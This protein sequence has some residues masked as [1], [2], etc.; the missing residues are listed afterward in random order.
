MD[1]GVD[2]NLERVEAGDPQGTRSAE[3]GKV[4]ERAAEATAVLELNLEKA[5]PAAKAGL[6]RALEASGRTTS[7]SDPKKKEKSGK[8]P[9]WVKV[10]EKGGK[11]LPPGLQ[12]KFNK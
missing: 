9:P 10:G 7:K 11:P 6:Q 1:Y 12:K 8:G 4:R 2:D 5:P 3:V